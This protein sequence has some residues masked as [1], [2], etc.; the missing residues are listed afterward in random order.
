MGDLIRRHFDI[1]TDGFV[2]SCTVDIPE[3]KG[4]VPAIFPVPTLAPVLKQGVLVELEIKPYFA[5][6]KIL[7][8]AYPDDS[9]RKKRI[10]PAHFQPI[11]QSIIRDAQERGYVFI[12]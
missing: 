11:I 6:N 2:E 5:K 4:S 10:T 1:G 12:D 3:C 9:N 8:A 7:T